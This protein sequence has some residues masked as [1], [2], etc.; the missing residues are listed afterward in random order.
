[1][2]STAYRRLALTHNHVAL[3]PARSYTTQ[4]YDSI[5]LGSKYSPNYKKYLTQNTQIKSFMHDIPL[6]L[7]PT[8]KTVN[9]VVEVPRWSNAKFEINTKVEGNPITQ[10]I[11]K[12][13]VRFIKN[14]FPFHGYIH[15]YGA[16]PQTWEDITCDN[17]ELKLYGDNDPLDV[18]EIGSK[19]FETGQIVRVKVLGSLALIDDGELDWKVVVIHQQDPMASRLN[20]IRDVFEQ[21]PNLLESTR[22]WFRNYKIPDGKPENQFAFGGEYKSQKETLEL[23]GETHE[24]WDRLV[25]GK[26]QADKSKLPNI[27]NSTIKTSPGF[28]PEFNEKKLVEPREADS[29][30]P[31]E[32]QAM[33][34]KK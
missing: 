9:M 18:V 7:D 10:D 26:I 20:D 27:V 8:T 14:L 25:H 13:N 30:I 4:G 17:G 11:K 29:E 31:E 23:I 32:V 28:T 34:F 5:D 3:V 2:N 21:C 16:I 15:N 12:G 22:E 19:V 6:Q 24:A 1:M 33:Y